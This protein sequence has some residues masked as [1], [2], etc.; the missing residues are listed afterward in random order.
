MKRLKQRENG[1]T[2]YFAAIDPVNDVIRLGQIDSGNQVETG[3]PVL[4]TSTKQEDVYDM[5]YSSWEFVEEV[6]ERP[7]VGGTSE[8]PRDI[9]PARAKKP[10]KLNFVGI[11]REF[12]FTPYTESEFADLDAVL[13]GINATDN[14]K[15][16]AIDRPESSD[17]LLVF[18]EFAFSKLPADTQIA[19]Q[20]RKAAKE[21]TRIKK[22]DFLET[23]AN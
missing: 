8:F 16:V 1:Q 18:S 14:L 23:T 10:S 20:A 19:L 7:E 9:R 12:E 4:Y 5:V 3:L 21:G 6:E 13:A 11:K 2:I 15:I 22:E 17:R